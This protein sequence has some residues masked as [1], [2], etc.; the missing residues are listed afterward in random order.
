MALVSLERVGSIEMGELAAIY[1]L[2]GY[3]FLPYPFLRSQPLETSGASGSV[4]ERFNDGDL[5]VFREWIVS[6]ARADIW[7]ECRV[8]DYGCPGTPGIGLLGHRLGESGFFAAERA[9]HDPGRDIVDV[10]TLSPYQLGA[11]VAASVG[12]T[13]PGM[14]PRI[15][16]PGY[17]KRLGVS[18]ETGGRD[19]GD[20]DDAY[21]VMVSDAR[22]SLPVKP[23]TF[24]VSDADVTAMAVIQSRCQPV[25]SWG[26][27]MDR[28]LIAWV[29]VREDGEYIYTPDFANATPVTPEILHKR[30]DG[31]IAEDVAV[32]RQRRGTS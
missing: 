8:V 28:K 31:L 24:E 26:P 32:L 5:R 14:H 10:F 16:I 22:W 11:A 15:D 17:A 20:D 1:E 21:A 23:S 7:V 18:A 13:Q 19:G 29:R 4:A 6:Y 25:Q 9:D 3:D 30:I 12:L 2:R 27:A